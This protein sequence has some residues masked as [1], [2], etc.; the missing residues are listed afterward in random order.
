MIIGVIP[1]LITEVHLTTTNLL[2][3]GN[4]AISLPQTVVPNSL[5]QRCR[6]DFPEIADMQIGMLELFLDWSIPGNYLTGYDLRSG[7]CPRTVIRSG[8]IGAF[9]LT[10][11]FCQLIPLLG[12][13]HRYNFSPRVRTPSG[14][15]Y[16]YETCIKIVRWWCMT[17]GTPELSWSTGATKATTETKLRVQLEQT[18][19]MLD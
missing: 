7:L 16:Q 5:S 2:N 12:C 3:K 17:S 6:T 1:L 15:L 18:P 13:L 10:Y 14:Y 4:R 8:L 11:I 19:F 9:S